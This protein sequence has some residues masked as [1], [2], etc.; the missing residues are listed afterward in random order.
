MPKANTIFSPSL[1]SMWLR[2]FAVVAISA[3]LVGPL[4]ID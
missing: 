1:R 2:A 4:L 3:M